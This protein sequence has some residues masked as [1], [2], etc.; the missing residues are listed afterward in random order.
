MTKPFKMLAMAAI[1]AAL[2]PL[3]A[4]RD[5]NYDLTDIDKTVEVKV[6][7]LVIP[8]NLDQITLS[9]IFKNDDPD[10]PIKTV[11][12]EY[13]VLVEGSFS[14]NPVKINPVS[15]AV[16]QLKP[17]T[18]QIF[19]YAGSDLPIPEIPIGSKSVSY[20]VKDVFTTFDFSTSNVDRAIRSIESLETSWSITLTVT[21]DDQV[22]TF[23]TL[24]FTKLRLRLPAGIVLDGLTSENGLVSIP[25]FQLN[26]SQKSHIISLP[27]KAIETAKMAPGEYSFTPNQSGPGTMKISGKVGIASGYVTAITEPTIPN[28]PQSTSITLSPSI[29]NINLL[30][31][32]GQMEYTLGN[33]GVD[34]VK[35]NG[36]PDLLT[37]PSTNISI[38]NP[39]LYLS[40]NNPLADYKMTASTGL[41][42]TAVRSGQAAADF[43][44]DAGQSVTIGSDKGVKGPYQFCLAPS[45]PSAFFT[46]YEAAQMVG[47]S[48]FGQVLSGQGLPSE[49]RVA[50]NNPRVGPGKVTRFRLDG[51]SIPGVTGNYAFY[52][53]LALGDG[54]Q[55]VYSGEDK[56]WND[57][58]LNK[59]TVNIV[60]IDADI[61]NDFPVAIDLTAYALDVNGGKVKLGTVTVPSGRGKR[62]E[63]RS[64]SPIRKL[65]G[66]SYMAKAYVGPNE[67]GK[68]LGPN[69]I[70]K[71]SNIRITVDGSYIDNLDK[72]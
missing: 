43:S 55:V 15:L 54:S 18:A 67:A 14:S 32:T 37:D 29:G 56:G 46:G 23:K 63:F 21:V 68:T 19:E 34:P 38:A 52:A 27:V 30:T 45:K 70:V 62:I 35:L 51:S 53:P 71:L 48:S 1:A 9:D 17:I 28:V 47:F 25:D 49:I 64:E 22:G 20:E 39:Q 58:M 10:S 42:L 50:F 65:D 57:D 61:D 8:V 26:K 3:S 24:N 6:N 40:L 66:I 31:F 11:G 16:G 69:A 44:L 72:K 41:T 13:A 7:N 59:L 60:K 2:L 5:E 4:C 36:L 33:F 12:S